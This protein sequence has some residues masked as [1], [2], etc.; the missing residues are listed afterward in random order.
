LKQD[1]AVRV[2]NSLAAEEESVEEDMDVEVNENLSMDAMHM[3]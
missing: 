3:E 1:L 2:Q